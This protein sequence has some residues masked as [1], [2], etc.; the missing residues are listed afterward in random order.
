MAT[1]DTDY[2]R[3]IMVE[4]LNMV[5]PVI[6]HSGQGTFK[7]ALHGYCRFNYLSYG[8]VQVTSIDN[9]LLTTII[10]HRL[11]RDHYFSSS[12][13]F[14]G[15]A[16]GRYRYEAGMFMISKSLRH[17]YDARRDTL[18]F[19]DAHRAE[20]EMISDN[21]PTYR[22]GV[23]SCRF[24]LNLGC[25]SF[26]YDG[27]DRCYRTMD[28]MDRIQSFMMLGDSVYMDVV[29]WLP[30]RVTNKERMFKI[31]RLGMSTEGFRN[32][33]SRI[34]YYSVPDD[35]EYRDDANP[36][37]REVEPRVYQ[38]AIDAINTFMNFHGPLPANS[39]IPLW[40]EFEQAGIPFFMCDTR[41][42]R[43]DQRGKIMSNTQM[44][45]LKRALA[46]P[47]EINIPFFIMSAAPFALQ[48]DNNDTWAGYKTQQ[49]SLIRFIDRR[50]IKNVFILTGDSHCSVCTRFR[51]LDEDGA[52]NNN[53]IV[54]IMSSG[55]SHLDISRDS[56]ESYH[57]YHRMVNYSLRSQE[58]VETLRSY[59]IDK[60]N[61]AE[62]KVD[63]IRCEVKVNVKDSHGVDQRIWR[64]PLS[65]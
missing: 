35:H 49:E 8:A 32:L 44:N 40:A 53:D 57:A 31:H 36:S 52:Y 61:F 39:T 17:E 45:A 3:R 33:F 38:S 63:K 1:L 34:P 48:T 25:M 11:R 14:T 41:Y 15:L 50:R 51:I 30:I 16:P 23:G 65:T 59:V 29:K 20:F 13:E 42:E 58:D 7:V 55:L 46:R 21:V 47:R 27:S 26:G 24:F 12:F 6:K 9:P 28:R 64:F 2:R 10:C 37:H 22:F 62:V 43:N 19:T 5:S 18:D 54:E 60:D 56:P 4:K